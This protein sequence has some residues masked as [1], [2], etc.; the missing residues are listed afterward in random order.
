MNIQILV[1]SLTDAHV[2]RQHAAIEMKKTGLD[3]SFID[4]VDGRTLDLSTA[5]YNSKKV[6]RLLGFELTPREI[7]CYLSHVKAWQACVEKTENTL[8]F[9]DD[10]VIKPHFTD[11]INA[12]LADSSSW[13]LVRLQALEDSGC[14]E[15]KN[16]GDMDLV[17]NHGDP[18]GAT[19]YLVN[20]KAASRLILKSGE[21]FEP[22]DHF[23]EHY[24][25]H[26][27]KMLALR[28][29]PV[30]VIDPTRATST[31]SDRP[32]R[33]SIRGLAKV[34]RSFFRFLDRIVSSDPLFPKKNAL[35]KGG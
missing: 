24:E 14:Q 9:E 18:L 22:L 28:P 3:W 29:Y 35:E 34:K 33:S 5:K 17:F 6:C 10:F 8:I 12:L 32:A 7:G 19:A 16:Y 4:A 25:K 27:V 13:D 23:I 2:R 20:P 30:T 15:I 1:I 31:I 21:V 26:G 11:A